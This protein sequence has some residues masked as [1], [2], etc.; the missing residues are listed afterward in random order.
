VAGGQDGL[1]GAGPGVQLGQIGHGVHLV[2]VEHVALQQPEGLLQVGPHPARV[3]ALRLAG[4]EEPVPHGRDE[5]SEQLLGP[6]VARGHVDVVDAGLEGGGE[7]PG[8]L[9][10]G[11]RPT[12]RRPRRRPPTTGVR[13]VPAV[14]SAPLR[15]VP[16]RLR[17]RVT[18]A[19]TTG[20]RPRQPPGRPPG[21]AGPNP[22]PNLSPWQRNHGPRPNRR[23]P[24]SR[25][26]RSAPP[27]TRSRRPRSR[28]VAPN[29]S[30]PAPSPAGEP[31]SARVA[32]LVGRGRDDG[33]W[34]T[35]KPLLEIRLQS[36]FDSVESRG[37]PGPAPVGPRRLPGQRCPGPG[38]APGP[39]SPREL[40]EQIVAGP[41]LDDL[42][43]TVEVSGPGFINLTLSA[44]FIAS[45]LAALA[46]DARLGV[47]DGGGRDGGRRLL[48]A[49]RG[50]GDARRPPPRHGH[51]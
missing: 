20:P 42:C 39:P 2:E 9:S 27:S 41:S 28:P 44:S 6:A 37:R 46:A 11:R 25:S 33:P 7:D 14:V 26:K 16:R 30:G 5:R 22:A 32:G 23:S 15:T 29:N 47:P 36:A 19:V 10:R 13:S 3:T 4:H 21:T 1:D 17:H 43:E 48:G 12:G 51:R 24:V 35:R 45:Q 31:A 18:A 34:S 50:Q 49:E 38:Q 40:A 8:R